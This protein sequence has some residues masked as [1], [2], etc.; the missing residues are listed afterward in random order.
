MKRLSFTLIAIGLLLFVSCSAERA[1]N[2]A[3]PP[4][5]AT[6]T[7][8]PAVSR[9]AELERAFAEIAK[10][11]QGRV[12]VYAR[13]VE[14]GESAELNADER[15]AM[16]SVVKVPISMAVLKQVEEGRLSLDQTITIDKDE[17]VRRGMHSPIRDKAEHS[18]GYLL[19]SRHELRDLIAFAVSE[20]DGTAADVVQRVAGGADGVNAYL[21][22][23]GVEA[24]KVTYTHKEFSNNI[25]R[26]TANWT[27]PKGAAALLEKLLESSTAD[28]AD[29]RA[30][31]KPNAELLL[32]FMTETWTGANRLKGMLPPGT[33]VAHKTGSSGT[34]NGLTPT[35]NDVGIITTPSGRR[36]LIAVLVG[37]S[38]ADE[39][40][41]DAVIARIAKAAWD[42]WAVG[43]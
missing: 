2:T 12:G 41:R 36:I 32:R 7:P 17:F 24:M 5:E 27:T 33:V 40:T 11:S 19:S 10:D 22:S 3:T 18:D 26:Q 43:G 39:K 13:V 31:T 35:A 30:L 20:S 6:P 28:T 8:T 42:K 4:A 34:F 29:G 16:Q 37:D 25:G 38:R 21:E 9:D 1:A 14:T 15:F 23:V